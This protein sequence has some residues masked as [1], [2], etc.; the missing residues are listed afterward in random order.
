MLFKDNLFMSDL[1]VY[2]SVTYDL[3]TEVT[4]K[5][6]N[7]LRSLYNF[8]QRSKREESIPVKTQKHQ[9]C[10]LNEVKWLISRMLI[11][12]PSSIVLLCD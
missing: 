2:N 12:I 4:C 6:H 8:Q 10:N 7:S 3:N 11:I 1:N 5:S 9:L